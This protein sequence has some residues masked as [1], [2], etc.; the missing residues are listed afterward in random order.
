MIL[1]HGDRSYAFPPLQKRPRSSFD[2]NL[3]AKKGHAVRSMPACAKE[4]A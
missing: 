1:I 3:P 4:R 2:Q